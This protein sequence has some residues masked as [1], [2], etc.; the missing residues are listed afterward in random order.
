VTKKVIPFILSLLLLVNSPALAY[1][2]NYTPEEE[3]ITTKEQAIVYAYLLTGI[4]SWNTINPPTIGIKKGY[5]KQP[6]HPQGDFLKFGVISG[7][8]WDSLGLKDDKVYENS[9]DFIIER[10]VCVLPNWK[11]DAW[12]TL[13]S[14]NYKEY[15]KGAKIIRIRETITPL[16]EHSSEVLEVITGKPPLMEIF[17]WEV[18]I[19]GPD[20]INTEI[21][22]EN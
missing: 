15:I 9:K 13:D 18:F 21:A 22:A 16:L 20:S 7:E 4:T 14:D 10:N 2:K 5:Y 11:V 19:E 8:T 17:H 3:A 6:G 1:F 12:A